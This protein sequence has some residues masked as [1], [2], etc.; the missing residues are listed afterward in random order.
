MTR[1]RPGADRTAARLA[2]LGHEAIVAPLLE[3]RRLPQAPPDLDGVS[4]LV[5]TSMNGVEA[6]AALT[7]TRRLP[8][9]TVG[10]ATAAAARAHGFDDVV[11]AHG[12]IGDLAR[13]LAS[14]RHD[15]VV[16][17]PGAREPAGDLPALVPGARL[18]RLPVYAAHETQAVV[19]PPP[20][21]AVLAH[22]PRAARALAGV[23]RRVKGAPVIIAISDAAAEPL[24]SLGPVRVAAAPTEA[25]MLNSLSLALGKAGRDV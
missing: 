5:F 20:L 8:V 24:R 15:G 2:A 25:A 1:A 7:P 4:A 9:F 19:P 3:I 12:A 16:L 13:L 10:D 6:F 23:W 11:S 14:R 21:A 22:S 17:A 18:R